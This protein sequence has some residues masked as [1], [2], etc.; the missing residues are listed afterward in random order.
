MARPLNFSKVNGRRYS[1]DDVKSRLLEAEAR[2]ARD[3]RTAAQR[4]LGDPPPERS[5]L[6]AKLSRM[7][8]P[9]SGGGRGISFPKNE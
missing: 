5:A 2:E 9:G 8:Q 1:A 7:N 4:W 3:T 6:A